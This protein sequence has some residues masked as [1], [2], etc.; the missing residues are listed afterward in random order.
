MAALMKITNAAPSAGNDADA[1]TLVELLVA[2]GNLLA[3]PPSLAFVLTMQR[4][5]AIEDAWWIGDHATS[6]ARQ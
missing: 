6:R 3:P 5:D 1:F 2:I 4:E